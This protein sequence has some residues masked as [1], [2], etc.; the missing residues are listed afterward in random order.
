MKEQW[1]LL[2][3]SLSLA[4]GILSYDALVEH[5]IFVCVTIVVCIS[6]FLGGWLW[7]KKEKSIFLSISLLLLGLAGMGRMYLAEQ[8]WEAA[9]SWVLR[10]EGIYQGIVQE[11]PLV[12]KGEGGYIRYLMRLETIGYADGAEKALDGAAYLY[13]GNTHTIHSLGE[14]IQIHG[15][16]S[17]LRNY[18]NPGKIDLEGRYRSRRLLG[19]IYP[20]EGEEIH[21]LG[22]S[23]SYS[24]ER[25]AEGIKH[26]LERSFAPY[27]DEQRL[28]ILMTL[29]FG[30]NYNEIPAAVMNSF[31]ATGIVHILSVSG[32]HVALLFS[33]LYFLGKWLGLPQ[34]VTILG[35]AGMVLFYALL[36]GLVPPVIRAAVMGLLTVGGIFLEREKVT[37]NLLGAAIL[38]ML[39][40]DPF[41]LYDVSFQLSVGASAGILLFYRPLLHWEKK[42]MKLP[43]WMQEGIALAIAAQL[44]TIPII[45]YDFHVFPLFFIPANLLVAPFLEWV[46][47]AGLLA[48]IFSFLYLP[49]AGGILQLAD[50]FLWIG[51]R[52]NFFLSA[53]PKSSVGIG[54]LTLWQSG[55]Y[56]LTLSLLS[57]KKQLWKYLYL[58]YFVCV[59]WCLLSLWI[60][61][62]YLHMPPL[63]VYCPDLGPDQGMIVVDGN[64]KILYYKGGGVT[65]YR[66]AW[67]WNSILGYEGIFAADV[68]ILNLEEVKDKVPLALSVPVQEIWVT[69]GA[70]QEKAPELM[71]QYSAPVRELKQTR[72]AI[73]DMIGSTNGSSWLFS[74]G[75]K[76]IYVS[77]KHPMKLSTSPHR[78]W[79]AGQGSWRELTEK[80]ISQVSP[81]VVVYSGNRLQRSWE[82]MEL[83]S[84]KDIP[85]ANTYQEGMQT[86]VFDGKWKLVGRN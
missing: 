47:I 49:L 3:S 16:M 48:A 79:L 9:S 46:I 66:S 72:L 20:V 84:T 62:L 60:G 55:W 27:M 81:E 74:T 37:L 75:D 80:D 86:V 51:L 57:L 77:G 40:W 10:S 69:G 42:W 17:P 82:D 56:Y 50:Y 19:R 35:T 33:F 34:K 38:G 30:G 22:D 4:L 63:R 64:K 36:A 58:R 1:L 53:L 78:F 73:G 85:A 28:H 61:F 44:L 25:L 76:E 6:L 15:T 7:K 11:P 8:Q 26:R 59:S 45:L 70:W 29:L 39:L 21:F 52:L 13:E 31:S 83:F 68:L 32:S 24:L 43:Q 54:G 71:K 14:R 23:G 5:D 12:M 18:Q 65:S 67:E 41:Y 2:W